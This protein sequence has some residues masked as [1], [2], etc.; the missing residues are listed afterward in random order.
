MTGEDKDYAA[1]IQKLAAGKPITEGNATE[2]DSP[3]PPPGKMLKAQDFR[4]DK[5]N[6]P[7]YPDG[8]T[9]TMSAINYPVAS[10]T[11]TYGTSAG[12]VTSSS[13]ETVVDWYQKN[14][15]GWHDMTIKDFGQFGRQ[16]KQ[17]LST[18]NLMKMLS[19]Q[20][21][22]PSAAGAADP[23]SDAD[24]VSLSLFTPPPGTN[25]GQSVA[26]IQKGG[27]PVAALLSLKVKP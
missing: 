9:S 18:D 14:L 10:D 3:D 11:A 4:Y 20:A 1:E 21:P 17:Q 16:A 24:R 2:K 8:V 25:N 13:F 6:L 27:K 12:I 7:R 5:T 22:P 26:V 15:P 19:G 23:S